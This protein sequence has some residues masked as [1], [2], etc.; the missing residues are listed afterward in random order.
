MIF[1]R[2]FQVNMKQMK[3][4]NSNL[5]NRNFQ[6]AVREIQAY[7]DQMILDKLDNTR[8]CPI[9]DKTVDKSHFSEMEDDEHKV[10]EVMDI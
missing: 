1:K 3:P 8:Y 4:K 9:C 7:E 10:Y 6:R 2:G 5:L